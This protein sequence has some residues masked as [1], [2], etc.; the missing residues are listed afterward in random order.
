M[1]KKIFLKKYFIF[2]FYA[3]CIDFVLHFS[4]QFG[5][6]FNYRVPGRHRWDSTDQEGVWLSKLRRFFLKI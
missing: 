4:L 6:N 1:N 2:P 3:L 5:I